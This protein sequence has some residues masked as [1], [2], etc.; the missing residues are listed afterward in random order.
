MRH[1]DTPAPPTAP[2][3][4]LGISGLEQ[5]YDSLALAIDQAGPD[6][7]DIFLV[8]LALL[9]AQALA[10]AAVFQAHV[11]TALKDL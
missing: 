11:A 6:K 3:L 10:D 4:G 5:V 9:N 2:A 7:S 8:K 1:L